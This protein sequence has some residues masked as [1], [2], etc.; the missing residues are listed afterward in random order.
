VRPKVHRAQANTADGEAGP[1]KM[2]EFH[3][4]HLPSPSLRFPTE[5]SAQFDHSAF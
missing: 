2:S 3:D 1:A 5:E 4:F